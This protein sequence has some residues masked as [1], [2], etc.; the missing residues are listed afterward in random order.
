MLESFDESFRSLAWTADSKQIICAVWGPADRGLWYP[1]EMKAI[2]IGGG[3]SK[4]IP[5]KGAYPSTAPDGRLAYVMDSTREATWVTRN[6]LPF[7]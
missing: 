6:L 1:K 7:N 4:V 3:T 2:P 5:V